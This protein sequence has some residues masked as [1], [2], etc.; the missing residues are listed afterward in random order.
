MT[1]NRDIAGDLRTLLAIAREGTLAGA[2][3]RL[4]VNHSTVFRR[5]GAI[6]ARLGTRLFERQDGA[7]ATTT[8]GEDL[9][10]TAERVEAE[11]E[12]LERRLSGQD[13][14]LTGSLRLTAPDDL[15]EIIVMPLLAEFRQTYPDITVELVIDNR[16]LNLTRREADI[17][18]R[19]TLRP[20]ETLAGRRICGLAT[21][22]YAAATEPED[23][24]VG[25]GRRWVAWEEGGGPQTAA[26]WMNE[27]VDRHSIAFRSNSMLNQASAARNGL[28]LAIVPCFLAD[29]DPRLQ[30]VAGPLPEL[31]TELW[32][33]THPDLQRTAR[34]RVLLDL[35]YDNLRR[36]RELFE[37]K[38]ASQSGQNRDAHP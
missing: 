30:R 7:Y 10:R 33:L 27:N 14:R 5:L 29:S 15:A 8:A 18:L 3:R 21:A 24:A 37:G 11:V 31:K 34:I 16:M 22:I 12:A 36:R 35:L 4:K 2:A 26:R 13:L 32:L 1:S 28:G 25:A 6:E 9:L 19:P 20:P 23:S 17:A 38:R